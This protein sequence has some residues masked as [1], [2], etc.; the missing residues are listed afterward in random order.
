MKILVR[1]KRKVLPCKK[2]LN[3]L[4]ALKLFGSLFFRRSRIAIPEEMRSP[5]PHDH[6]EPIVV[7]VQDCGR[8]PE[9]GYV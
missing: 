6:K 4:D 7:G 9:N 8:V 5:V 2:N 1:K 3:T